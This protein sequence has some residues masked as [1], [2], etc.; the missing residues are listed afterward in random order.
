MTDDTGWSAHQGAKFLFWNIS[1]INVFSSLC[2]NKHGQY[3]FGLC[4]H[5]NTVTYTAIYAQIYI[6][7]W[8]IKTENIK[9]DN[10]TYKAT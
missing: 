3:Q 4:L 7:T 1:Y 9:T 10:A 6:N 8:R 5:I 2:A